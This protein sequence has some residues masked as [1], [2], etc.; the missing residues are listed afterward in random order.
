MGNY[1]K[2]LVDELERASNYFYTLVLGFFS[3]QT[4][5]IA[6]KI[7]TTQEKISLVDLFDNYSLY[8]L[9]VGGAIISLLIYSFYIWWRE[10]RGKYKNIYQLLMLPGNRMAIPL[11][12]VS[13]ILLMI[14]SLLSL[15]CLYMY[16]ANALIGAVSKLY[17]VR[18]FTVE[19]LQRMSFTEIFIPLTLQKF[20]MEYGLGTLFLLGLSNIMMYMMSEARSSHLV[21]LGVVV[22]YS[23]I[24][25]IYIYFVIHYSNGHMFL[26]H[27]LWIYTIAVIG[28]G[29]LAQLLICRYV[30][31]H[32]LSI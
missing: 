25:F 23:C 15:Q 20:V 27:E 24:M 16:G 17:Y 2:L 10:W 4:L 1:Y 22:T 14:F 7:M 29:L 12:K 9:L 3:L 30:V 5:G 19:W 21:R 26:G 13:T 28:I 31:R 8:N 11:A 6:F 18:P 32:I